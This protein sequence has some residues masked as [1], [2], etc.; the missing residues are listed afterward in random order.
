MRRTILPMAAAILLSLGE[1]HAFQLPSGRVVG[2]RSSHAFQG[3][4]RSLCPAGSASP[5]VLPSTISRTRAQ[6]AMQAADE[7]KAAESAPPA[8]PQRYLT[9]QKAKDLDKALID[10]GAPLNVLMEMAGLSVAD[11]FWASY[12]PT[13]VGDKKVLCVAGKGNNGGGLHDYLRT[14]W[15]SVEP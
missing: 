3:S 5:R 8:T 14:K 10:G 15:R 12:S 11:A 1:I 13:K 6:V 7:E 2:L 4:R 9:A